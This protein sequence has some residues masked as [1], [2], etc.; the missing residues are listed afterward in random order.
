M[1]KTCKMFLHW[2]GWNKSIKYKG[3]IY[4]RN[5]NENIAILNK[6]STVLLPLSVLTCTAFGLLP[7]IFSR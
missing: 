3:L 6:K 2:A 5:L 4:I 1:L 7:Y